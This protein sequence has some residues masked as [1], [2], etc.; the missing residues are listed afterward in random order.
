MH[1]ITHAWLLNYLSASNTMKIA[2]VVGGNGL[3]GSELVRILKDD[4]SYKWIYRIQRK[5]NEVTDRVTSL[6]T[7]FEDLNLL[8]N[9]IRRDPSDEIKVFCCLGSTIKKAGSKKEFEKIDRQMVVR[10]AEWTQKTLGA[11]HFCVVSAMGASA[12]S[13][14]FYNKIKGL[15][16]NDLK[17]LNFEQLHIMRPSLLLGN[18]GERRPLEG[19]AMKVM[20]AISFL[21]PDIYKPVPHYAVAQAMRLYANEGRKGTVVVENDR[22]ILIPKL[23]S[24]Q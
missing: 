24:L 4:P 20:P 8:T 6:V 22:L 13:S 12:Q 7:D 14:V 1:L 18:R 5:N 2:I 11:K 16:E 10:F 3:V 9:F 15:M 23:K 19:L 21:L 17:K